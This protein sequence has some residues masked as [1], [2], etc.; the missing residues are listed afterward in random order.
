[1]PTELT[2]EERTAIGQ[3]LKD[4]KEAKAREREAAGGGAPTAVAT[5]PV[6]TFNDQDAFRAQR[7][8]GVTTEDDVPLDDDQRSDFKSGG[9]SYTAPPLVRMYKPNRFGFYDPMDIADGAVD[10]CYAAGYLPNCPDCGSTT[11]GEGPGE[12]CPKRTPRMYRRCPVLSC[13]KPFPDDPMMTED[14]LNGEDAADDP[15][16]INDDSFV[17]STP[18]T[19]TRAMLDNHM[20]WYHKQES[21]SLAPHLVPFIAAQHAAESRGN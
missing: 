10:H 16:L 19:R 20:L 11:C 7:K 15:M 14:D 5:R 12:Q 18:E 8:G 21:F 13:R 17:N 6:R 3:R 4:G 9:R 2:A 1:M